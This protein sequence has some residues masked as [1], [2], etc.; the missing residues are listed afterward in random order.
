MTSVAIL[1]VPQNNLGVMKLI[2]KTLVVFVLLV[3]SFASHAQSAAQKPKRIYITL[4][5]SG[6]MEGNK[7]LMANYAAQ[8]IAV[9]SNA[10][11]RVYVRSWRSHQYREYHCWDCRVSQDTPLLYHL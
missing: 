6:S 8:S 11:D 4:D 1:Y 3:G 2:I 10:E 7:Y 5:V 9:F